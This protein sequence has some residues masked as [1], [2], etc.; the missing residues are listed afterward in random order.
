MAH[1]ARQYLGTQ[2][3]SVESERFFSKAGIVIN[4]YRTCLLPEMAEKLILL[5]V[6]LRTDPAVLE[7]VPELKGEKPRPAPKRARGGA[8]ALEEAEPEDA[9]LHE[10]EDVALGDGYPEH[11]GW[12]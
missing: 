5:S 9:E 7:L 1:L 12:D 8:G 4:R 6:W 11:A 10:G 2:V 3:T